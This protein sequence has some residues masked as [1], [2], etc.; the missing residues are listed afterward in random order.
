MSTEAQ[1]VLLYTTL[2]CHL[3]DEAEA[4]LA[5]VMPRGWTI[6]AIDIAEDDALIEQYGEIIPV[7]KIKQTELKWPFSLL[8]LHQAFR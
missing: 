7:V 1:T 5:Q 8:D 3:C 6:E 4:L 2:G